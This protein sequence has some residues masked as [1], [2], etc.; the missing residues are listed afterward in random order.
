MC[1]EVNSISV[2]LNN[3]RSCSSHGQCYSKLCDKGICR[4]LDLN[5]YCYS[6]ADCHAGSYCK[7][8][9]T[10]PFASKC[11]KAN[12]NFEQCTDT[13][14]CGPSAY[15]WFVSEE[16]RRKDVK[17]CLP[18]Y[19]QEKGTNM[20]W[21]SNN[22]INNLTADDFR[23]NGMYCKSGL[24]F[25][26]TE[27]TGNCTATDNIIFQNK[28][29]AFPFKCDPTNQANR[30]LVNYNASA[31]NDAVKLDQKNFTVGCSCAMNGN[32]GYCSNILGT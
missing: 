12:T 29:I 32:D 25:P 17:K 31:P 10:W 9:N 15:C 21:K 13:Y 1:R 3:G 16:D 27:F 20:G 11:N 28:K 8:E 2:N 14:Q 30:C 24:A 7:R 4:G 23:I 6:H 19:S 26:I 22:P 18:L 5:E